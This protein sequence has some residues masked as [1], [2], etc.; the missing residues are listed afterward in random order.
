MAEPRNGC[1]N[2]L[3]RA[4][5]GVAPRLYRRAFMKDGEL[6]DANTGDMSQPVVDD[7]ATS[8]T[9]RVS[10]AEVEARLSSL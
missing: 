5:I 4:F 9:L 7:Y 3:F 10:H 1:P 2:V 8:R 6:K